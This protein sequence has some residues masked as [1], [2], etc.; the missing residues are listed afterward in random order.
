MKVRKTGCLSGWLRNTGLKASLVVGLL[1]LAGSD[2]AWAQTP[3]ELRGT[4]AGTVAFYGTPALVLFDFEALH[5]PGAG[6][7]TVS[8]PSL[9]LHSVQ[10]AR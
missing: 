10:V 2:S 3:A 4:W 5:Q 6:K 8:L 1:A 9:G 7:A